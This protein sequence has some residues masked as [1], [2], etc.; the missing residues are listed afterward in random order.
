MKILIA[1]N[2]GFTKPYGEGRAGGSE[3]WALTMADEF[4]RL[5]HEV[6]LVDSRG[7]ISGSLPDLILSAHTSMLPVF[8]RASCPVIHTCHGILPALEQPVPGADYYVSVSEEVQEHLADRGYESTVIR[9]PINTE[10]FAPTLPL[11]EYIRHVYFYSR[12]VGRCA[13]VLDEAFPGR[14]VQSHRFPHMVQSD[15]PKFLNGMDLVVGLGRSALE[16]MSCGRNVIIYDYNGGDG[17]CTPETMLEFRKNNC[18]GRRYG[19]R[20]NASSLL[21]LAENNYDPEMGV[22][23]REYVVENNDV[24]KIAQQY[25]A[26]V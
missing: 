17:F 3:T 25:L 14:V 18:S 10:K 15:V 4:A 26:L 6:D 11:A 12:Y 7:F 8:A 5:G 9:N 2:L 23:L 21:N 20:Y 1:I 19:I 24:R 13:K 22:K 16:A